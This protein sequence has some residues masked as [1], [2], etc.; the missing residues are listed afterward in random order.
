MEEPKTELP[1]RKRGP[2]HWI[3]GLL[4]KFI[5]NF[6]IRA[7]LYFSVLFAL[8][9]FIQIWR[10]S[11]APPPTPKPHVI[12]EKKET[13]I[14]DDGYWNSSEYQTKIK[15]QTVASFTA[16]LEHWLSGQ[17]Q[18]FNKR[19]FEDI[20]YINAGLTSDTGGDLTQVVPESFNE[21]ENF[22]RA[23]YRYA[24]DK[25]FLS[26]APTLVPLG[27]LVCNVDDKTEQV[28]GIELYDW[29]YTSMSKL[30][31]FMK[32]KPDWKVRVGDK[33][34]D[35]S[36]SRLID[37]DLLRLRNVN[38]QPAGLFSFLIFHDPTTNRIVL[39][40]SVILES[41]GVDT[42]LTLSRIDQHWDKEP[43]LYFASGYAG[44]KQIHA[45]PE[46]P[47]GHTD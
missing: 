6:N 18:E 13:V 14:A 33:I 4:Q 15:N 31:A 47:Y 35:V 27:K 7:I 23:R 32:T 41:N 10:F 19:K 8:V 37:K 43:K 20:L 17:D 22:G 44:C 11:S 39:A 21:L 5:P 29:R 16:E 34:L 25:G 2:L 40:D 36:D 26:D 28:T 1:S 30:A 46:I 9:L 42:K 24:K 12:V 45:S 38:N 3:D